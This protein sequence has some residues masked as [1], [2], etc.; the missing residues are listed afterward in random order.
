MF[1]IFL[2]LS[3]LMTVI[4]PIGTQFKKVKFVLKSI[5]LFY[6]LSFLVTLLFTF[7]FKLTYL[8]LPFS[9]CLPFIDPSK[10][11][12]MIKIITWSVV[13]TQTTSSVVIMSTHLLLVKKLKESRKRIRKSKLESDSEIPLII[14]LIAITTS[15]ILCWFPTNAIYVT[16]MFLSTYPI[17]LIIW[18]TVAILPLNS[19]INPSVFIITSCRKYIKSRIKEKIY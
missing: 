7:Y 5:V 16:A 6:T 2:S 18:T 9:L 11:V 14:Q 3:R 1:Q 12:G 4:Y 17:D 19:I 13:T 8:N 10:S 15:N